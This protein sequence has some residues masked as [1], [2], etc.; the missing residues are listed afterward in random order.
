MLIRKFFITALSVMMAAC[1]TG[2]A[3]GEQGEGK[4]EKLKAPVSP[5]PISLD[6]LPTENML[7]RAN[8]FNGDRTRIAEKIKAAADGGSTK[9]AFLGDSITAGSSAQHENRYTAQFIEWWKENVSQ[10]VESLNAGI[11]AT[12]SY[13]AVHRVEKDVLAHS[14]DI[15]FIEFIN[16]SDT[17]FYKTAM[18]S[19]VRKCLAQENNP[20]VILIEM[21]Q[22]NGTCPQRV[23]SEVAEFYKL[24]IVS[25]HDAVL[26]EVEAGTLNWA[27]ISPDNIHPNDAGHKLLGRLLAEFVEGVRADQK[28]I[29]GGVKAFD[30]ESKSLMGDRYKNA[31]LVGGNTLADA[32]IIANKG[33]DGAVSSD[34]FKDGWAAENGGTITFEAEFRSFGLLYQKTVDG[35]S[36]TARIYIDGIEMAQI[37]AD[38][39]GGWGSYAASQEVV[40]LEK[41]GTHTVTVTVPEGKRF[42]V[43]RLMLS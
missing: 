36:G 23:H 25:Y 17:D 4:V 35:K 32:K 29:K 41:S 21:T 11:G 6:S 14:P 15:I 38:F 9:I 18:E 39:T 12:D 24:P 28:K 40:S 22:E 30:S 8:R 16:D 2:C 1:L 26:P 42:E 3:D 7:T 19:L 43:L 13:L 33:F 27:D 31:A 37:D 34:V 20:A 5:E 10:N